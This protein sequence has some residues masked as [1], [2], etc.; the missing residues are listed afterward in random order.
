MHIEVA[1]LAS[2]YCANTKGARYVTLDSCYFSGTFKSSTHRLCTI[3]DTKNVPVKTCRTKNFALQIY[4]K[5]KCWGHSDSMVPKKGNREGELK[6]YFR[7]YFRILVQHFEA[8]LQTLAPQLW[9]QSSSHELTSPT[10]RRYLAKCCH[11]A[12]NNARRREA[13]T[14]SL[15]A[16][17][18]DVVTV[19]NI[20]S[21]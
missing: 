10:D 20:H 17:V 9:R 7:T 12:S 15:S 5:K 4:K 11:W 13:Q 18:A 14:M 19:P 6:L 3:N 8:L 21:D 2:C 16:I 1:T